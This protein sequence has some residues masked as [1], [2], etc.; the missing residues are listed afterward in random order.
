MNET[1]EKMT[2][3]LDK[4]DAVDGAEI[5]VSA[6]NDAKPDKEAKDAPLTAKEE[7]AEFLKTAVVAIFFAVLI[8]TFFLEPFNIPSGSMKPTLLIGD[9]LFVSKPAYGYS[10]YSFP[11]GLAP[12]QGRIWA[13]EPQRGDIVVFKLPSNTSI[14][15]IKR[16]IGMPGD[17]IQVSNG[18]LY[19]NSK[20]IDR[21]PLGIE[22]DPDAYGRTAMHHYL[23]T[24]PNGVVHE[25]Y[26]SSDSE[27]LDNTEL[28]TVPE[29]HYFMM[30][31]NRDNSQDSRVEHIVGFVPFENI[32]GRADFLFFSTDGSA[33][34]FEV[35]KWPWAL[36][37]DRFF[38]D[39]DPVRL[40]S[41]EAEQVDAADPEEQKDIR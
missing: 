25:I 6:A 27:Q 28:F 34:M 12:I 30:G 35:W 20:M 14:D 26:E 37:Y 9:Y 1:Q 7:M 19:I 38:N 17:T 3:N 39:I 8:R 24:L 16:I 36:R 33:S 31:D 22:E 40:N 13:E 11:F 32:V 23:E 21:E 10:R 5:K 18:R 4:Q 15:Y 29:G 41:D 2:E